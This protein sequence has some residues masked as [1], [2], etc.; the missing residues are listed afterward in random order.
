LIQM[1]F[2]RPKDSILLGPKIVDGL[3]IVYFLGGKSNPLREPIVTPASRSSC[4]TFCYKTCRCFE[5]HLNLQ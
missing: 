3:L 4:L 1:P 5:Q 2:E